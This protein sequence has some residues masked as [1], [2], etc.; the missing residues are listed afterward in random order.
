MIH[1]C[2]DISIS[3]SHHIQADRLHI[4]NSIAGQTDLSALPPEKHPNYDAQNNVLHWRIGIA[5]YEAAADAGELER[6]CTARAH[7]TQ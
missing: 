7:S 4:L 5:L 1:D 2:L 3:H 6:L